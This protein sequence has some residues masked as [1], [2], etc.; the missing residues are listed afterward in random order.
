VGLDS[1]AA[2]GKDWSVLDSF[3]SE[4]E[5]HVPLSEALPQRED[6]TGC[7]R[8]EEPQAVVE[9]YSG[10]IDNDDAGKT[11]HIV[12]LI[13]VTGREAA[14]RGQLNTR[15][16]D[17]D[18]LLKEL[19]HRVKNN[20]QLITALIR[21]E[22]RSQRAGDQINLERLTGRIEAMYL[23]YKDLQADGFGK[24]VDLGHY[25]SQIASA[26][27]HAYGAGNI[28]L[29]LKVGHVPVSISPCRSASS[30]TSF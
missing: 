19:Q 20:L 14:Q 3:R 17:K 1:K 10:I 4:E 23:L 21:L 26:M 30:S 6:F 11:Y 22:A 28:R 13:D 7:F 27:M 2:A 25:V 8:R 16:R 9:V 5:P 12:A 18:M 29:D 15:L 24:V